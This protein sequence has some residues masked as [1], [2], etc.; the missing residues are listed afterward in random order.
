MAR[1]SAI[2]SSAYIAGVR[3][4]EQAGG[5]VGRRGAGHAQ[6]AWVQT[7]ATSPRVNPVHS[8]YIVDAQ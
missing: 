5:R 3:G 2:N 7:V 4:S 6:A 1:R 8:F